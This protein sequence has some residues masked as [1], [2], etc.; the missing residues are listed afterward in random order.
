MIRQR[1]H[2]LGSAETGSVARYSAPLERATEM[3]STSQFRQSRDEF[4]LAKICSE[5]QCGLVVRVLDGGVGALLDQVLR[6]GAASLAHSVVESSVTLLVLCVD[7][8][9]ACE[10]ELDEVCCARHDGTV[11]RGGAVERSA[12]GLRAV[13]EQDVDHGTVLLD[14]RQVKRSMAGEILEVGVR[15]RIEKLLYNAILALKG[16]QRERRVALGVTRIHAQSSDVDQS[17]DD[18]LVANGRSDVNGRRSLKV[19]QH[20]TPECRG[21]LGKEVLGSVQVV[22]PNGSVQRV[23]YCL[24]A[25]LKGCPRR[26]RGGPRAFV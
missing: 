6:N 14:R 23:S 3:P 12:V 25:F 21:H 13:L 22:S 20:H 16:G 8:R 1:L 17:S 10:E 18:V 26:R 4:A 5:I 24:G 11:E 19:H 2:T 7:E 9:A 15:S